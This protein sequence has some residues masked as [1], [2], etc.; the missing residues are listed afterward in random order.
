M[1][2]VLVFVFHVSCAI[3]MI[4]NAYTGSNDV[5]FTDLYSLEIHTCK[6]KRESVTITV[7][8]VNLRVGRMWNFA[9]FA[10]YAY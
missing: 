2:S 10:E 8:V 5:L 9:Y 1:L 4:G 3:D 6:L 7:P